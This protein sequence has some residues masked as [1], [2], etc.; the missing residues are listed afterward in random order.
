[1]RK[2]NT[3]SEYN[4]D[5]FRVE[6]ANGG[7]NLEASIEQFFRDNPTITDRNLAISDGFVRIGNWRKN[8][9]SYQGIMLRLRTENVAQIA[10]F[11]SDVMQDLAL[12]PGEALTEYCCFAYYPTKQILV[13]HRSRNAGGSA[14]LNDYLERM[15]RAGNVTLA[16]VL[17]RDA[18]QRLDRITEVTLAELK[19]AM[20]KLKTLPQADDEPAKDMIALAK[21]SGATTVSA[22]LSMG[23]SKKPMLSAFRDAMKHFAGTYEEAV[24]RAVVTGRS[25]EEPG[26]TITVDLITDR[27]R[28]KVQID[29][30]EGQSVTDRIHEALATAYERRVDEI[31]AQFQ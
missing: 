30:V 28:E 5:F 8:G 14:R 3:K 13:L 4:F 17:N 20:P 29:V 25:E 16:V 15:V 23:R 9:G 2:K 6:V 26:E 1:M 7:S 12:Q 18:F 21:L 27:M 11:D 19:I 10:R 24:E 22:T 31:N